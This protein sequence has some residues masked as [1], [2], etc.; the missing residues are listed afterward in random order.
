MRIAYVCTDPGV[1]VFGSKGSSVHVQE[2]I[3]ALR[4]RGAE[5]ELF[6]SRRGGEPPADL[7]ELPVRRL[8]RP[9]K[10]DT[11]ARERAA[12]AANR[13]L[14]EALRRAGPFDLVYERYALWSHAGMT[15]AAEQGIPALLEVNAPL[16]EEQAIH[17]EL[18]DTAA[19][20]RVAEQVFA[21]ADRLLAVSGPV[22]D[23]LAGFPGTEG[24]IVVLPNGVDPQR[25]APRPKIERD[26][27][28]V[29]F[30]GTLKPWHGLPLLI[31]AFARLHARSP[32]AR[33]LIVGDGP[34]RESLHA[35]LDGHGLAGAA[36]FTGAVTPEQVPDR[37][38]AMDVAVAPYPDRPD[39]YFSPLKLFEYL[40][41]GLPV[42]AS[43]VGQPAE[44][45]EHGVN[46][47]LYPAG[48][49]ERLAGALLRLRRDPALRRR[50]GRSGRER[51]L[52][53][54]SW[55]AVAARILALAEQACPERV[56]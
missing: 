53:A 52:T 25:F 22:A 55:D 20:R 4:R 46:G 38:A 41:M 36:T 15:H 24:R 23:Y 39:S 12:L 7:A 19:A 30:L 40:A 37:L 18:V 5:V 6:A 51:V 26:G 13:D 11:A 47:L 34:E 45:I 27:F 33:L 48:D 3:R 44:I 9:P 32:D 8:P 56:A 31:E 50:L 35:A 1:P 21:T 10:G 16:I 49:A 43:R 28:T 42:V 29:G 2:V 14:A 17:R 54:H